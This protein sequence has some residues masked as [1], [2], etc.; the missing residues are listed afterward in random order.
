MKIA[1]IGYGKMGKMIEPIAKERGHQVI[2]VDP[3]AEDAT[4]KSIKDADLS[5]TDVCIDFSH[6]STAIKN[7]KE[8]AALKKNMVIGTTGWYNE[9]DNV[10]KLVKDAGV[11]FIFSSNFS[12]GVNIFY[13]IVSLAAAMIDKFDSYD[14]CGVEYHHNQK[15]DSPSGTA[16]TLANLILK[17][18][19]RKNKAIFD[20]INRQ[21]CSNELHFASV[22]CG[23]I[24][25]IHEISI[26]SAADT[27]TLRHSARSRAGFALGSVL[28]AEW[29]QNKQ[30]FF[31][32]DDFMQDLL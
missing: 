3:I 14:I 10:E 12:I 20:A 24:P 26:D 31:K 18:M 7:I 17:N 5:D 29:L 1:L 13:K 9:I 30:G 25:G 16:Q 11:G 4:Y 23:S 32:I 21:I 2:T 28:A 22:R 6:P 15:A 8:L 19:K 27:I